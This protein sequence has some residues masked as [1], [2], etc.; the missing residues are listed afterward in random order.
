MPW[1]MTRS[2]IVVL[3][4]FVLK[5]PPLKNEKS[6]NI[7]VRSVAARTPKNRQDNRDIKKNPQ[8]MRNE[9]IQKVCF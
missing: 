7:K 9:K 8:K 4:C 5:V 2:C 6:P 1:S 3:P